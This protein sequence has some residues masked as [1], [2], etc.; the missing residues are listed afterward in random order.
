MRH[1]KKNSQL[2]LFTLVVSAFFIA[3][4]LIN[5]T[6]ISTESKRADFTAING[7]E[8]VYKHLKPMDASVAADLIQQTTLFQSPDTKSKAPVSMKA[9]DIGGADGW[10]MSTLI[11]ELGRSAII[12][13]CDPNFNME[14]GRRYQQRI[15]DSSHLTLAQVIPTPIELVANRLPQKQFDLALASHVL[16]YNRQRWF[17][18]P[19]IKTHLLTHL[20]KSLKNNGVLCVILQS[21]EPSNIPGMNSSLATHEQLEDLVYPLVEEKR[22]SENTNY[23]N[24]LEFKLSLD[25]YE[26]AFVERFHTRPNWQLKSKLAITQVPL[27]EVNFTPDG[28]GNYPQSDE[29]NAILSFYLKGK[30]LSDLPTKSQETFLNFLKNHCRTTEQRVVITHVNR[31]YT[32]TITEGL[33]QCLEAL[34]SDFQVHNCY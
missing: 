19:N 1:N 34:N 26:K 2:T 17:E 8:K 24:A 6:K 20:F 29:V 31:V 10:M 3:F 18:C 23:A 27:G 22:H 12:T 9:L 21:T 7:V 32:I 11:A 4:K 15:T 5:K 13:V 28:Q 30:S 25:R 33:H 14:R 16:Y